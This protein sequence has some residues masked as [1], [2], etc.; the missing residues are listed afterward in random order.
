MRCHD[1]QRYVNYTNVLIHIIVPHNTTVVSES[2]FINDLY[3]IRDQYTVFDN[4]TCTN[5]CTSVY[6]YTYENILRHKQMVI[7]IQP[8]WEEKN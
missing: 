2:A 6:G 1:S 3:L 8:Y 5:L 4:C 7:V